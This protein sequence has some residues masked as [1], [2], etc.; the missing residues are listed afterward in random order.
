[1]GEPTVVS[2]DATRIDYA[3]AA[4]F[5][6]Q[7]LKA[8]GDGATPLILDFSRV[9]AISSI[10]LRALV[11]AS[12]RSKASGGSIAIAAPQPLV[13]EIFLISRFDALF[14]LFATTDEARAALGRA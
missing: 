14:G 4:A 13:R 2:I 3:S 9:E 7:L 1:M 6:E 12:K 11:L 8:L 5:Q 10:G